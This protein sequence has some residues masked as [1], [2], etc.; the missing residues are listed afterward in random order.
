MRTLDR[1]VLECAVLAL[2]LFPDDDHVH[3][4]VAHVV[5]VEAGQ[6]LH[7]H[8][9]G[10]QVKFIPELNELDIKIKLIRNTTILVNILSCMKT[11]FR[12]KFTKFNI[13]INKLKSEINFSK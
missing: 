3:V 2:R 12:V 8:N 6:G 4:L 5:A 1:L 13:N 10:I 9:V 7:V 11:R